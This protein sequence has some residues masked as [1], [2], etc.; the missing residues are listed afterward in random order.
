LP[1]MPNPEKVIVQFW[2]QKQSFIDQ[3]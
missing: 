1:L 3:R 2:Y